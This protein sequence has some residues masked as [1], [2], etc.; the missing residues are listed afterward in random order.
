[1]LCFEVWRNGE[2]ITTAGLSKSGVLSA[3]LTWVGDQP[4][5]SSIAASSIGPIPGIS[6]QVG[7]IDGAPDPSGDKHVDWWETNELKIGD[8]IRIQLVS[9]EV[10]N[11]PQKS[12]YVPRGHRDWLKRRGE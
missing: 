5:A 2:K 8:E 4:E 3:I 1:M 11:P 9:S 6:F 7:G 12:H 10:P